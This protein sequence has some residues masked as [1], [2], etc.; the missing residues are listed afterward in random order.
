MQLQFV[1]V[2]KDIL[3]DADDAHSRTSAPGPTELLKLK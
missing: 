3:V 2:Y 1:R